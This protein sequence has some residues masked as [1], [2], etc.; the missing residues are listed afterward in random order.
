MNIQLIA[1]GSTGDVQ[2]MIALGKALANHGHKVSLTAFEAL[3]SLVESSGL[4]YDPLPGDAAKYIGSIIRPGANPFSYLSRFEDALKDVAIPMFDAIYASCMDADAIVAA[5][6]G[7]TIYSIA[8]KLKTPLFQVS[9]CLTD[10]TGKHCMPV[11]QQPRWGSFFNEAT[12]KIAY[13]MIGALENRY[14]APWCRQND[15]PVRSMQGRPNYQIGQYTVPSLYAFSESL[16]TRPPEWGNNIHITGFW[17]D[18]PDTYT[19]SNELTQFLKSDAQPVYIGFGSMTSGDMGDAL[20]TVLDALSRTGLRA[21]LSSGWGKMDSAALP[22][23]VHVLREYVPH[24]CLFENVRAV[25]H[26]GGAGTTAAGLL[27][28]KPSLLVP[29]GSDQYFWGNRV[30]EKGCGPKPIARTRLHDKR[31]ARALTDLV[32]NETYAKN[33]AAIRTQLLR[34]NGPETAA[35]L[36]ETYLRHNS[37]D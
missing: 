19:L 22:D 3:R 16:V 13:R 24:R 26:H 10:L 21:V 11:M 1:I 14:V 17:D 29:F 37:I 32:E 18:E 35:S 8:E 15:L 31:L 7:T 30:Y 28:G 34:E 25:V 33:A 2:P 27:A 6:F 20:R 9:Y 4:G 36:I 12:Y 23:S 5:F